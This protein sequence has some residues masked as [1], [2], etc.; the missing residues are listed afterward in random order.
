MIQKTQTWIEST[1]VLQ[2]CT[3]SERSSWIRHGSSLIR[4]LVGEDVF[5]GFKCSLAHA[6]VG[7]GTQLAARVILAGTSTHP[8]TIERYCWLGGG[9]EVQAGIT[10]AEGSIIGAGSLVDMDI[11]PYSIT[12]G[13]PARIIRQREVINDAPPCFADFLDAIRQ[14]DEASHITSTVQGFINADITVRGSFTLGEQ[15]YIV[16]R[17]GLN[18]QGGLILG[19]GVSIASHTILEGIGGITLGDHT[20]IDEGAMI[21]TT[22]HD[23]TRLSLPQLRNAV[24]IGS[25]VLVGQGAIILAG[26]IIGD[27]AQIEPHALVMKDVSSGQVVKKLVSKPT[28]H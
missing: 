21:F 10:I 5:I 22:T 7:D 18:G 24:T 27:Y 20:F 12:V 1:V 17:K 13:C 19:E 3:V 8:I 25:H 2:D 28:T 15:V 11:P 16:G 9:V 26:V 4:S 14:R 6:S 23:Y